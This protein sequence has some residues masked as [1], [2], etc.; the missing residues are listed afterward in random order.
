MSPASGTEHR[1]ARPGAIADLRRVL[2]LWHGHHGRLALGALVACLAALSGVALL[3]LAGSGVARGLHQGVAAAAVV[4]LVLLRPL[5]LVR[6]V[7]RWTERMLTHAATFRALAD[8]RVWFFRRLADRLPAGLGLRRAGDVLGRLVT[9]VEALDGL[10]LRALVPLT[11]AAA[12]VIAIAV[13]LGLAAPVLALV[14]A[15]PLLLVLAL[16]ALLAPGAARASAV[17]AEARG[18]LRARAVEP[19]MGL[20]DVLAANGEARAV[21]A[22]D[23]AA[24]AQERA[25]RRLSSAGALGGAAGSLLWQAALLGAVA[26]GLAGG[27][28]GA[29]VS[30]AVLALFL[31]LAAG[32]TLSTLPRAGAALASAGAAARRWFEAADSPVLAP[33]PGSPAPAPQGHAIRLRDVDFRWAED[34]GPVFSGLSLDIPEGSRVALLGPSGIGKSTLAALLLRLALPQSGSMTLGGVEIAALS[35]DAVRRRIAC[36]TQDARLFDDTIAANLRLAAPGA[37]DAALWDALERAR[38]ADLVRALPD[39]LETRCGEGGARFSGGQ[40]RR[41]ALARSLLSP[42]QVLILDEP[43]AGLDSTAERE[44]LE[45]LGEATAGRTVLLIVHRLTGVER[46]TRILRLAGGRALSAAG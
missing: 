1:P 34:R 26:W 23:E 41:I 29:G 42:A 12:V 6:P 27:A 10:Y 22:M 24:A 14:V 37:P 35:A 17:V 11:A 9:D 13:T 36:L 7:M 19:L 16:L 40:A 38:I 30:L 32:E 45:T 21:A 8:P 44:F 18:E 28:E 20:E 31:A 46:P 4:S 25:G 39:G 3:G 43:A 33:E 2:G 5:I 15:L